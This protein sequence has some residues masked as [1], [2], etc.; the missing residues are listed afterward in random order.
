M[1]GGLL[2]SAPGRCAVSARDSFLVHLHGLAAD[3]VSFRVLDDGRHVLG[4][5]DDIS[6]CIRPGDDL[7][8]VIA[9][10]RKLADAAGEMAM[11]LSGS[12]DLAGED[13]ERPGRIRVPHPAQRAFHSRFDIGVLPDAVRLSF[14]DAL[15][16]A[17]EKRGQVRITEGGEIVA[18][19]ILTEPVPEKQHGAEGSPGNQG[20]DNTGG[21]PADVEHVLQARPC[22]TVSDDAHDS[23]EQAGFPVSGEHSHS[24]SAPARSASPRRGT[25]SGGGDNDESRRTG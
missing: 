1:P 17:A 7:G 2:R 15:R 16:L 19:L 25:V 24:V 5:T 13:A 18:A 4:I 12:E 14:H 11:A 9:G 20:C 22:R 10:L 21:Q 6:L 3:E 8:A 23:A